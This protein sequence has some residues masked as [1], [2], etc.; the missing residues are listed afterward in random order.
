MSSQ[1]PDHHVIIDL[2]PAPH[3]LELRLSGAGLFSIDAS[4][5]DRP[6]TE[7]ELRTWLTDVLT[8]HLDYIVGHLATAYR[9]DEDSLSNEPPF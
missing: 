5:S 9:C 7:P 4:T 1:H 8:E 6:M 2:S 3:T